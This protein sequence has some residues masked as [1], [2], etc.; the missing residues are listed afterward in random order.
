MTPRIVLL[1]LAVTLLPAVASATTA[2]IEAGGYHNCGIT[3]AGTLTCWGSNDSGQATPPAG[4]FTA[5]TAGEAHSCAI[6]TDQSI[7]CWGANW[8]GQANAPGGT[9]TAVSA[10]GSH[11]CAIRTDQTIACWGANTDGQA[12]APAGTFNSVSSGQNHTCGI[13]TTGAV[14]CWGNDDY[15]QAT[16]PAGTFAS[17]SA[18]GTHTC[19]LR[20]DASILCWGSDIF[21]QSS[22]PIELFGAV[23][24]GNSHTCGV[25][26]DGSVLCWGGNGAGQSAP[27][28]DTFSAVTAGW[29]HTCGLR[30][31]GSLTCWGRGLEAQ[32]APPASAFTGI[33]AGTSHTCALATDQAVTCW[34]ENDAFQASPPTGT[35]TAVAAGTAY[36]CGILT[37]GT[38]TCWGSNDYGRRTPPA[39]TFTAIAAASQ[40]ACAIRTDETV[41]CWGRDDAGQS[42][43][44]AG[45]FV[46]IAAGYAHSCG[47]RT[48]ATVT[49]WGSDADGQSTA[50]AGTFTAVTAGG[51][52]SCA[53]RTD[54]TATCWGYDGDGQSTAPAGTFTSLAAAAS[55]TCGLRTDG[56]VECWGGNANRQSSP[57]AGSF[58]AISAADTYTCGIRSDGVFNCWGRYA[59]LGDPIVG[60]PAPQVPTTVLPSRIGSTGPATIWVNGDGLDPASTVT[61]VPVAGGTPVAAASVTG[62][63]GTL[64]VR[65]DLGGI[66][67]GQWKVRVTPPGSTAFDAGTVT[68]ETPTA[69][70]L[71][72]S[73]LTRDRIRA[74]VAAPVTVT[75][76]NGGNTDA[77]VVPVY[78]AGLPPGTTVEGQFP[79]IDVTTTP[80]VPGLD[81]VGDPSDAGLTIDN[82][83]GTV[84]V[85]L[86]L[87]N[88]PAGQ[89]VDLTVK[90]TVPA[91]AA[92][93]EVAAWAAQPL[94]DIALPSASST[95][96]A[97]AAMAGRASSVPTIGTSDP[98]A[99]MASIVA[100][101][102]DIALNL[103]PGYSCAKAGF[104]TISVVQAATQALLGTFSV[105]GQAGT[106]AAAWGTKVAWAVA[107]A[108]INCALD[109]L[110]QTELVKFVKALWDC[111][112][113]ATTGITGLAGCLELT[114]VATQTVTP[115]SSYDPNEKVGPGGAGP[116]GYTTPDV[117]V[118]YAIYF[119]NLAT[120][121]A[122]AQVVTVTDPI[123]TTAFDPDTIRLGPV[124]VGGKVVATP[125]PGTRDWSTVVPVD[126]IATPLGIDV[127]WN[128]GTGSLVWTLTTLDPTT[129]EPTTDPDAGFLPPN[130]SPP[131]G[132]GSV[133]VFIEPRQRIDGV[134]L[135]NGASIV[136]DTNAPI[137]TNTWTNTLD[138][139][140]PTSAVNP[141]PATTTN[142][143]IPVSWAGSDGLSGVSTYQVWVST[144]DGS[145]QLWI[146]A[147]ASTTSRTWAG[148][149]GHTYAFWS[150]ATDGAGNLEPAPAGPDAT[151]TIPALPLAIAT[152]SLPDGMVGSAYDQAI[153]VVGGKPPYARRLSGRLPAGMAFD[154]QA[155][156]LSGTPT[157]PGRYKLTF[158]A[159]DASTP[160]KQRA[161]QRLTLQIAPSAILVAPDT[162]PPATRNVP[163][164]ATLAATGGSKRYTW[165]LADGALPAGLGLSARGAISGTPTASG[166]ATFTIRA[167]DKYG[168]VGERT[169]AIT[170]D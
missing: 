14:T 66:A 13:A 95:G 45:T 10:G 22:A 6:A 86:L 97:G 107:G 53:V 12:T 15:G 8:N 83:D 148:T 118:G 43:A 36:T 170:T 24:A 61:L 156:V 94:R 9:F 92:P 48:D 19:G 59:A 121:T 167:T 89:S 114:P 79:E 25:R 135:T 150:I 119:E 139:T 40:H 2:S 37:N 169:Y 42:T 123:D 51:S 155:G 70:D 99:C 162:L 62:R 101:A 18:G 75:V 151:V 68:V 90:I 165:S 117:P 80:P 125:P 81:F 4:T 136:F 134:V 138:G 106:G 104:E 122:A 132:E 72:V 147:P 44:P 91:G 133:T 93:F 98:S 21:G 111:G 58:V 34:G 50:P 102:I 7:T 17:V 100:A 129:L 149:P 131:A 64:E 143:S 88:V 85:P 49:C 65:F 154:A 109:I 23:A 47:I 27:P 96:V 35:F 63:P 141:L 159:L 56:D 168:Y 41:A 108:T 78:I 158:Q 71:R 11:T 82:G 166:V 105:I 124:I 87:S 60:T 67:T 76:T 126:G 57:P 74:G 137:V 46:A 130:T 164:K 115:V 26:N 113:L 157:V 152:T 120:A 55:H 112:S 161:K 144:D 32:T 103:V 3:S 29:A 38:I 160:K 5:V 20:S 163:Y 31:D 142:P 140:P 128:A 145:P 39:G 16:S 28:A 153:A 110:P 30:T 69:P 84:F 116:S 77:R 54:G 1:A 127:A 33:A 73:L 52:H 146:T